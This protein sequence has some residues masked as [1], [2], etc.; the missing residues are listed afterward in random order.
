MNYEQYL[1]LQS[2]L[3]SEIPKASYRL[4]YGAI[5][6]WSGL[7]KRPESRKEYYTQSFLGA[8]FPPLGKF[9]SARD[10]MAY[11]DDYMSNRGI[12]WSD[13]KYPSRTVGWSVGNDA[14]SA[15][16]YVSSNL[17]RLYR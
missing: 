13:V 1:R 11:M 12:D 3:R 16:N 9:Y 7:L 5:S 15:V 8:V 6:P 2:S 17:H 4:F 14:F 10:S